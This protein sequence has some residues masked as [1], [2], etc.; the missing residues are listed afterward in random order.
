MCLTPLSERPKV[1]M[2]PSMISQDENRWQLTLFEGT[3]GDK[4]LKKTKGDKCLWYEVKDSE[5][6][7]SCCPKPD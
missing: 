7:T 4:Y 2:V 6:E 1:S 3:H 5:T